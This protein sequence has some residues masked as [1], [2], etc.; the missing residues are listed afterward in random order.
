MY[1]EFRRSNQHR[2]LMCGSTYSYKIYILG[3]TNLGHNIFGYYNFGNHNRAGLMGKN[4]EIRGLI[5]PNS[6]R[7][8][9]PFSHIFPHYDIKFWDASELLV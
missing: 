7:N 5:E 2:L 9:S 4:G 6:P 3:P 1:K 8:S